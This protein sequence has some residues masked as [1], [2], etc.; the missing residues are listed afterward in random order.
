MKKIVLTLLCC[1][2]S[3]FYVSAQVGGTSITFT[4]AARGNRSVTTQIYYPATNTGNNTPVAT[5]QY[6]VIAF[7]HGFAISYTQ[8]QWLADALVPCGY[9][10]AFP[11]TETGTIF[12][13]PDHGEFGADLAFV[14]SSIQAEGANSSSILFG[15]VGTT[16]ALGGHSMGGGASFLGAENNANIT[17]LFNF[18]AAETNP[19]AI[20]AA[21]NVSVPTLVIEGANDCVAPS[22]GNTGDMFTALPV[23]CKSLINITGASH[24]QFASSDLICGF[25]EF[26]C[27]ASISEADQE[28]EVLDYLKPFLDTF[29]KGDCDALDTAVAN[30]ATDPDIT[31]TWQCSMI[32]TC[33]VCV[34]STNFNLNTICGI[35]PAPA[36]LS[37][38]VLLEGTY[39]ATGVMRADLTTLIPLTQ[40]YGAAPYNYAGTE[41]IATLPANMVDWV[42]VEARSGTPNIASGVRQTVT[43]ETRAALLLANGDIVDVDGVSPVL[44]SNLTGGT[45]YYFCVRHRNHL[46]ILTANPVPASGTMNYDFTVNIAQAIGT[47]QLKSTGDGFAVM[48]S[49]DFNQDHT[50]QTTDFDAWRANSAQLF[51]YDLLDGNLDQVVQTTDYDVWFPNKAKLATIETAY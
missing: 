10:V 27:S 22:A 49:G 25:G 15:A 17:A 45:D 23:A 51:V 7:G 6:P 47:N 26:S 12:P 14:V 18:A 37:M 43:V 8:Y 39:D 4:D 36:N 9:I 31:P 32:D 21:A 46:D 29:L 30:S 16:S 50:I 2:L 3:G 34:S 28:A 41:A 20:A 1:F 40:P 5:G 38:K 24:C 35:G 33:N 42:L 19:S 11:D 13:P 44:F 48:F